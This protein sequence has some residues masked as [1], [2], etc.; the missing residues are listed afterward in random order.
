MAKRMESS[1][2]YKDFVKALLTS[3]IA[4]QPGATN[5]TIE[6]EYRNTFTQLASVWWHAQLPTVTYT[7]E[8]QRKVR[9]EDS[10]VWVDRNVKT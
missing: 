9:Y 7:D 6:L 1:K 4:R 3:V 2:L 8:L 10:R 5:I